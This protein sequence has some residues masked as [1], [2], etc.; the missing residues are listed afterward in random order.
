MK[1]AGLVALLI[2]LCSFGSQSDASDLIQKRITAGER[3]LSLFDSIPRLRDNSTEGIYAMHYARVVSY[4]I[5][6]FDEAI[7][8]ARLCE[9]M[10]RVE[11][12]S[13]EQSKML[14]EQTSIVLGEMQN[15]LNTMMAYTDSLSL[16]VR[17]AK[18]K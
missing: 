17:T 15:D 5:D 1:K 11:C 3:F 7:P 16:L 9:E 2:V 13:P 8:Q 14:K 12:L 4:A 6:S 18:K 10:S